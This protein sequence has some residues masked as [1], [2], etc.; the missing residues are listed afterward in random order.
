MRNLL[1]IMIWATVVGCVAGS[2]IGMDAVSV[3]WRGY[4]SDVKNTIDR[5]TRE[6]YA[7]TGISQIGSYAIDVKQLSS[8]FRSSNGVEFLVKQLSG[9][10]VPTMPMEMASMILVSLSDR[11]DAER[12]VGDL[13]CNNKALF[14]APAIALLPIASL[15]AQLRA[16]INNPDAYTARLPQYP[17]MQLRYWAMDLLGYVGDD[18]SLR[19]VQKIARSSKEDDLSRFA[20]SLVSHMEKI[21]ALALEADRLEWRECG[22]W[23][24]WALQH[25]LYQLHDEK[26]IPKLQVK[27]IRGIKP[28]YPSALLASLIHRQVVTERGVDVLACLIQEM[29]DSS[30][31]PT[32]ALYAEKVADG[33]D[34]QVAGMWDWRSEMFQDTIKYLGGSEAIRFFESLVK[35]HAGKSSPLNWQR[36]Y[37]IESGD[38]ETLRMLESLATQERLD[39]STRESFAQDAAVLNARLEKK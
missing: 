39:V 26:S 17:H 15:N 33:G 2:D 1:I 16:M 19:L 23:Y 9:I 36:K 8:H 30:L 3:P 28:L 32:L 34:G 38:R 14:Y 4:N 27:F 18:E 12:A 7:T 25:P 22:R 11:K 5:C 35:R 21:N 31:I 13:L 10:D 6:K 20:R 24:Y 37:L 29:G